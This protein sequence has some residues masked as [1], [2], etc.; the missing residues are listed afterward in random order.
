M[1]KVVVVSGKFCFSFASLP[2]KIIKLFLG[3]VRSNHG[4]NWRRR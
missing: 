3:I 4:I 2:S 1:D